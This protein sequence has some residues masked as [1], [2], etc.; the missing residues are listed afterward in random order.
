MGT[1]VKYNPRY[2]HSGPQNGQIGLLHP[3]APIRDRCSTQLANITI[4]P[5]LVEFAAVV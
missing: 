1:P 5:K 2:E 4:D 3:V